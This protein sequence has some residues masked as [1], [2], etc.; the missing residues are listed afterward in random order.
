MLILIYLRHVSSSVEEKKNDTRWCTVVSMWRFVISFLNRWCTLLFSI[1]SAR[2]K[3]HGWKAEF[4]LIAIQNEP[5]PPLPPLPFCHIGDSK[6]NWRSLIP[7]ADDVIHEKIG[8]KCQPNLSIAK[9]IKIIQ[10]IFRTSAPINKLAENTITSWRRLNLV[11][12]PCFIM[13]L[14]ERHANHR[15]VSHWCTVS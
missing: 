5:P 10:T 13:Y 2:W 1:C 6:W 15:G 7:P 4:Y 3:R 14:I 9:L 11:R 8:K 12:K